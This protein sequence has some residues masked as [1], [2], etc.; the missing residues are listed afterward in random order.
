MTEPDALRYLRDDHGF[1]LRRI[2][3]PG[4]SYHPKLYLLSHGGPGGAFVGSANLTRAAMTTNTE[5]GIAMRFPARH[6]ELEDHWSALMAASRPLSESEIAA[7]DGRRRVTPPP[8]PPDP[9]PV[10]VPAPPAPAVPPLLAAIDGGFAPATFNAMWVEAGSMSSSGSHSQLELPRG[11]NRFFGFSFVTYD[12]AHH[13]IGT[14][15]LF[16]AGRVWADRPLTWHGNN[17]MERINLP[18][19]AQGGFSYQD[20]AILFRR[21]GARFQLQVADWTSTV[22][23]TWRSA[24]A[25]AATTFRLGRNSPRV[26]GFF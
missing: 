3:T 12:D 14:P 15:I 20:R 6:D 22:A 24:S 23:A 17:R 1:G 10:T 2:D 21:H 11:A 5:M 16:T 9:A 4:S 13:T 25:A 18:T 26:C 7:Y 19:T 8:M